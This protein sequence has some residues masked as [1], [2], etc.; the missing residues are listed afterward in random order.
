M[1]YLRCE[2]PID[3]NGDAKW[4]ATQDDC[5]FSRVGETQRLGKFKTSNINDFYSR[6]GNKTFKFDE[7][8]EE[9]PYYPD[10]RERQLQVWFLRD[11]DKYGSD[12]CE[13]WAKRPK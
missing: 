12:F 4:V 3:S 5:W 8:K 10:N 6:L 11:M 1:N 2:L 9:A 7:L 13:H